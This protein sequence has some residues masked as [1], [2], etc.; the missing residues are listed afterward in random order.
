[1]LLN[2]LSLIC[3]QITRHYLSYLSTLSSDAAPVLLNDKANPYLSEIAEISFDDIFTMDTEDLKASYH[4]EEKEYST[5]SWIR[6]YYLNIKDASENM[7]IRK[8]NFSIYTAQKY[9]P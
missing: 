5:F 3:C 6:S 9:M 1:M 4:L 2:F 8:F 7:H